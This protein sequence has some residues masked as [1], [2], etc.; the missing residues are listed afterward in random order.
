M[1]GDI[2]KE[3]RL[4][5]E[6]SQED[7]AKKLFVSRDLISKWETNKRRPT[8]EMVKKM[9]VI[10]CVSPETIVPVD[11]NLIKELELCIP[12]N[13]NISSDLSKN[14]INAFLTQLEKRERSIFISRYYYQKNIPDICEEYGISKN[15]T[16]VILHRTR[17]K[18]KKYFEEA[19]K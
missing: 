4:L 9:A 5:S 1:N 12:Q 19:S 2:I 16:R 3:L 8:Q 7:L 13:C 18:L 17:K 6:L 11:N 14:I 10:F 15:Y